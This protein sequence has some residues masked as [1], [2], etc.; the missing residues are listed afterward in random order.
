MG[1]RTYS[2]RKSR[3]LQQKR[4]RKSPTRL[5]VLLIVILFLFYLYGLLSRSRGGRGTNALEEYVK[6]TKKIVGK[7]NQIA[8]G[9]EGLRFDMAD[10]SRKELKSRLSQY[11]KDSEKVLQDCRKIE[12]P[13]E[14]GEAHLYL[15]FCLELRDGGLEEYT[16]ALFNALKDIDL[17][18]ASGQIS[19]ALKELALSDRAYLKFAAE[20][21][22]VLKKKGVKKSIPSSKF[23]F[24]DTAY[25][26]ANI[27]AYL[28]QLK[29]AKG[30]EEIHG[31]GIAKLSTEPQQIRYISSKKLAVLPSA[32]TISV[33]VTIENQGNQIESNVPVRAALKSVAIPSIAC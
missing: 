30:L 22:Q 15:L 3:F 2:A 32:D 31:I 21:K 20:A 4:S 25:E 1:K 5:L 10:I 17:E 28:Q 6:R 33:T 13:E 26:K 14:M 12:P 18:V 19:R 8:K 7:S 16:P 27:M 23:L 9:F 24:Q 29:G 11:S